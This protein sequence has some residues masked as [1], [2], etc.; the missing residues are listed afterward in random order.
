MRALEA[1]AGKAQER[2]QA[3]LKKREQDLMD[4]HTKMMERQKQNILNHD[5][6]K[7]ME[8]HQRSKMAE[9]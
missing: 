7:T 8:A 9:K 6:V 3:D 1:V 4:E 5:Y 2:E